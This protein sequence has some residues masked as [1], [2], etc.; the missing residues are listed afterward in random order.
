MRPVVGPLGCLDVAEDVAAVGVGW[1]EADA[2]ALRLVGQRVGWVEAHRLLVEQRAEELR[3]VVDPQPGRLVGEQAEGGR[4]RL[5]EAEAG[6]A[7][8]LPPDP[9]RRLERDPV[10]PHGADQEAVVV[11]VDRLLGALAAHRP[12]QPVRLGVS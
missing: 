6:E 7:L 10:R 3:R 11:L 5:G 12:P 4:V 1:G 8:D 9:L 2:A